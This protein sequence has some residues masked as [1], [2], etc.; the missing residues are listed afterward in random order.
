MHRKLKE[1]RKHSGYTQKEISEYL[2]ISSSLYS[3]VENGNRPLRFGYIEALA[4]LYG[5]TLMEMLHEDEETLKPKLWTTSNYEYEWITHNDKM[6][7][8]MAL[9]LNGGK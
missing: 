1:L 7:N 9:V 6:G 5:I 3:Q 8:K 4:Q 2:A